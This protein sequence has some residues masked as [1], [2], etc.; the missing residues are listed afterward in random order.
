M[1][2]SYFHWLR[3]LIIIILILGIYFRFINI[4]RKVY[5]HDEIITSV[6]IAG[7]TKENFS[8]I[9]KKSGVIDSEN[10]QQYLNIDSNKTFISTIN[11]LATENP[12]QVPIYFVLLRWWVKLFDNSIGVIRSFSAVISLLVFPCIYWLCRELFNKSLVGEI[13][14]ALTAIS[15]ILV[16]YAQ[17]ARGYSLFAV[18]VLLSTIVLF[19]AMRIQTKRSWLIYT[20]SLILNLYTNLFFLSIVMG[21]GLYVLLVEKLR[22]T[23]RLKAYLLASFLGFLIFLP[24]IIA[25]VSDY[26]DTAFISQTTPFLTLA[27]R[28][29]INLG[30]TFLDIQIGSSERLF[31]VRNVAL[32]NNALLNLNTVWPYLLGLIL[33]LIL[34][35]IYSVC[36]HQPKEVS[37]LILTFILI[38]PIN[39]VISDLMSGGQRSSIARYLIPSYLGI[40]LCI[41]Y[42]LTNKLTN[43]TEKLWFKASPFKGIIKKNFHD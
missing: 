9:L 28:W 32:D 3:V 20:A 19:R 15:P 17:E 21:H 38:T 18:T 22:L 41:A 1:Q 36:Q 35:S 24:W 33:V 8:D 7:Y 42:L 34:Y 31:D 40:Y 11:S 26:E 6:R 2:K 16:L 10:L 5:W 37:L 23:K 43:F 12:E 27:T 14:I 4:D 30:F 29:F 13:A 39:M 25:I